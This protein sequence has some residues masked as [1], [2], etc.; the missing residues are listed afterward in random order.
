MC[1]KKFYKRP[2]QKTGNDFCSIK[3]YSTWKT[4][5]KSKKCENCGKTFQYKRRD[6][7]FCSL[8]CAANRPK[9][10]RK[11]GSGKNKS[12]G[13]INTL[14]VSGWDGVCMVVGCNHSSTIDI[15]RIIAGKDGGEYSENN[16][17]AI[18]PNHHSE[19]HRLNYI[20]K[21]VSK[22]K[23]LLMKKNKAEY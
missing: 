20:L 6:Q 16:I 14:I 12:N 2:A 11:N 19:I 21:R 5:D 13:M 7:R 17:C 23:F 3:C 22:F 18:C 8:S 4:T 15:H 1:G 9:A 10:E